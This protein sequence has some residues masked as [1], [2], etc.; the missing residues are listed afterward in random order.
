MRKKLLGV[1]LLA[2][3]LCLMTACSSGTARAGSASASLPPATEGYS[4]A[5]SSGSAQ[6]STSAVTPPKAESSAAGSGADA[7]S[8]PSAKGTPNK[9]K[10]AAA[11]KP[12][13]KV[14]QNTKTAGKPMLTGSFASDAKLTDESSGSDGSKIQTWTA[15]DATMITARFLTSHATEAFMDQYSGD[16]FDVVEKVSVANTKGTHYRWKIGDNE[17]KS[18]VDAVVTESG[19]YSLLFLTKESEDTFKGM[20][21]DGPTEK[22][23]NAWITSLAITKK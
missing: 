15:G 19:G 23:V 22:T 11:P 16:D 7:A 9:S 14:Q 20:T 10:T 4:S 2:A 8:K 21:V 1:G 6:T 13:V 3:A 5:V 18:V 12:K 17:D